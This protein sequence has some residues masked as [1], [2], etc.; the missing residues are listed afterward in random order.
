MKRKLEV[1][2]TVWYV[3]GRFT[4]GYSNPLHSN[5]LYSH[6]IGTVIRIDADGRMQ[7]SWS[8]GN[9][10]LYK[11]TD[12]VIADLKERKAYEAKLQRQI[13]RELQDKTVKFSKRV[14][15]EFQQTLKK[16][17]NKRESEVHP[18]CF[19]LGKNSKNVIVKAERLTGWGGCSNMAGLS[20]K[21]LIDTSLRMYKS[22]VI[23]CGI[24]RVGLFDIDDGD[25]RG[26]SLDEVS[27]MGPKAFIVSFTFAGK[28]VERVS[29]QYGKLKQYGYK[30]VK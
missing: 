29:S 17:F 6:V 5:L 26:D 4:T 24:C 27:S 18:V 13:K 12:L 28:R 15:K 23:P 16:E 1:G 10:N 19:L 7:V 2:D 9:H 3:S 30:V 11:E 21:E 8:N 22:R 25:E 14:H 20:Q